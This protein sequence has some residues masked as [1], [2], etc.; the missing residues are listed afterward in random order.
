MLYSV[1]S[2]I[3][4]LRQCNKRYND[5]ISAMIIQPLVYDT[6]VAAV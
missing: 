2:N 5:N 6:L 4:I 3:T 1:I